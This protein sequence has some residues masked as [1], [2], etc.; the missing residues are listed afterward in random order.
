MMSRSPSEHE[1]QKTCFKCHQM[2]P[3]SEFYKHPQ[4]ADGHL[5]K[6]KVCTLIDVKLHRA[7]N[8]EKVRQSRFVFGLKKLNAKMMNTAELMIAMPQSP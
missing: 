4:M 7:E 5:N 2:K 8:D 6:C 3:L 1:R